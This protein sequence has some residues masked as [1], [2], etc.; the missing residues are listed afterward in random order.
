MLLADLPKLESIFLNFDQVY[1]NRIKKDFR[2]FNFWIISFL[3]QYCRGFHEN[4]LETVSGNKLIRYN[5][6]LKNVHFRFSWSPVFEIIEFHIDHGLIYFTHDFDQIVFII[7]TIHDY[8]SCLGVIIFI[9]SISLNIINKFLNYSEFPATAGG[10]Q[11][12]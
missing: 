6:N 10:N 3:D 4:Q 11:I 12:F 8:K 2:D 1:P 9:N 7:E 5:R